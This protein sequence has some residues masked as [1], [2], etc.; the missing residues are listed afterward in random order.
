MHRVALDIS[1]RIY[2]IF[3]LLVSYNSVRDHPKVPLNFVL[4]KL[5]PLS[6]P[7]SQASYHRSF[8]LQ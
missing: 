2:N 6:Y 3:C 5:I 4:M 1:D 8:H 7:L